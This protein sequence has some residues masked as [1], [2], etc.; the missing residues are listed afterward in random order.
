MEIKQGLGERLR[1]LRVEQG[2]TQAELAVPYTS[3]FVSQIEN[4]RKLPSERALSLFAKKLGVGFHELASG[5]TPGVEVDVVRRLKDGWRAL[6][7]GSY[8]EANRAFRTAERRAR[9]FPDPLLGA[10]ALVG[11]AWTSERSGDTARA[12]CLFA[13]ALALFEKNAS[14]PVAV[15]AVAGLARCHQMCG[16][17]AT[18]LYL[19]ERYLAEL[20]QQ[21][22]CEPAAVM[23]IYASL[24]WP[25]LELGLNDQAYEAASKALRLQSRVDSPEEIAGMHLNVA[26]ALLARGDSDLA[27]DSLNRAE[28]IYRDLNWQT[29]IARARTARGILMVAE[30]RLE[31]ARNELRGALAVFRRVGFLREEAR[32]LNELARVERS[33][34]NAPGATDLARQALELLTEMEAVPEQAL[35]HRELG[36]AVAG[37]DEAE[38]ERHLRSAAELYRRCG[39]IDHAADTYRLI[40]DLVARRMPDAAADE[41]R[42]GL[43]LISGRLTRSD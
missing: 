30:A 41:Y 42:A 11:Q 16:E 12:K 38:A 7:L 35:A 28:E 21:E 43:L 33:L 39:E 4:G 3:A 23:R 1:R 29:E 25:Y 5:A 14:P 8:D 18:S 6:Y 37:A 26:R 22:L 19:L 20:E 13:R 10:K 34:G 36:L 31:E 9:G 27:L 24:V 40:G 15:E 2:M 17:T 32:T